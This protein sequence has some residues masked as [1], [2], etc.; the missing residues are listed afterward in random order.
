[1]SFVAIDGQAFVSKQDWIN[2]GRYVLTAHPLYHNTEHDGP[3][4]GYR[5]PHF[6]ALCF[7]QKGRRVRQG[8]DFARAE[9]ED[10]FPVWWI[11]PDQI[12]GLLMPK[13]EAA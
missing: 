13:G 8:S 5:G 7:D 11:W 10:A 3:A 12:A 6:T 9:A 4:K 2:R 1:M